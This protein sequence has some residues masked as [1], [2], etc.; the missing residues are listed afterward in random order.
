MPGS[1]QLRSL[2][3]KNPVNR[4]AAGRQDIPHRLDRVDLDLGSNVWTWGVESYT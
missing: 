3:A 1:A 4:Q 2:S